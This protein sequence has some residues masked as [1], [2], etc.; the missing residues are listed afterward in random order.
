MS[1]H[2][3]LCPS[4]YHRLRV[5]G[6]TLSYRTHCWFHGWSVSSC[7]TCWMAFIHQEQQ[8]I[9]EQPLDQPLECHGEGALV[10]EDDAWTWAVLDGSASTQ[11]MSWVLDVKFKTKHMI[12]KIADFQTPIPWNIPQIFYLTL[13]H[14]HFQVWSFYWNQYESLNDYSFQD[15][16]AIIF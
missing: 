1:L 15:M 2:P 3:G 13:V 7:H 5:A 8:S 9:Q 12:P 14:T 6:Q 4:W 10:V 16:T 11:W